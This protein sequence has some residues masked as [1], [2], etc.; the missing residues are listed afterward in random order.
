MVLLGFSLIADVVGDGLANEGVAVVCQ[1][2]A[3]GEGLVELCQG[4]RRWKWLNVGWDFI[5][6]TWSLQL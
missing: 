4:L 2:D 5:L 3:R 1:L 6:L